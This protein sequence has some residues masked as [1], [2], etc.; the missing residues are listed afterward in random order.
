MTRIKIVY[1]ILII[2]FPTIY[3]QLWGSPFIPQ[4]I[5]TTTFQPNYDSLPTDEKNKNCPI[6]N[7][8]EPLVTLT[9]NEF[10]DSSN[11]VVRIYDDI[12]QPLSIS[13]FFITRNKRLINR[14]RECVNGNYYSDNCEQWNNE[15][16]QK[17]RFNNCI[18]IEDT[19][20]LLYL[21]ISNDLSQNKLTGWD[22]L[23]LENLNLKKLN[24]SYNLIGK[25][26]ENALASIEFVD[27]SHN[28]LLQFNLNYTQNNSIPL[29]FLNIA[30]N[31]LESIYLSNAVNLQTLD[32]S[33][34]KIKSLTN[35]IL[36]SNL[37]FVIYASYNKIND[38]DTSNLI[39][40]KY[41]NLSNNN[42]EF[43]NSTTLTTSLIEL[44]LSNNTIILQSNMNETGYIKN[45][46]KNLEGT[47]SLL[48]H[49]FEEIDE[50]HDIKHDVKADSLIE[51]PT[52]TTEYYDSDFSLIFIGDEN[53]VTL[54]YEKFRDSI[55]K[56]VRISDEV[57]QPISLS[58]VF[59]TRNKQRIY[60][61]DCEYH[62]RRWEDCEQKNTECEL[63]AKSHEECILSDITKAPVLILLDIS[64]GHVQNLHS[65]TFATASECLQCLVLNSNE[66]TKIPKE[67]FSS[68]NNLEYLY[69]S[70][71]KITELNISPLTQLKYLNLSNNNIE[72]INSTTLTTSLIALDLSNNTIILQSNMFEYSSNLVELFLNNN[73]I[74]DVPVNTFYEDY[75]TT[76][77]FIQATTEESVVINT[78][79]NKENYLRDM[80]NLTNQQ[81]H[82]SSVLLNNDSSLNQFQYDYSIKYNN[83]SMPPL[84]SALLQ[85]INKI[86]TNKTDEIKESL[87]KLDN[88]TSLLLNKLEI[89]EKKDVI[90]KHEVDGIYIDAD[91]SPINAW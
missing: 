26:D 44:D 86:I 69:L 18:Q 58:S 3:S 88:T 40:L 63:D 19:P 43:I 57:E 47:T 11:K 8:H 4:V 68:L 39:G 84:F 35:C 87:Q 62:Y 13:S 77:Y 29:N 31:Q 73:A 28:F 17:F 64:N 89:F 20:V 45:S 72:F 78:H 76:N 70:H 2:S 49:K 82:L 22:S 30:N 71:N 21:D 16:E 81:E 23:L 42:I 9:Y 50:L 41:L 83:E 12:E 15:C 91:L 67:I 33:H 74:N 32:I 14:H 7:R 25:L 90:K 51:A 59:I 48:L 85:N 79:V 34:N 54:T 66:I 38:F 6:Y 75:N 24:L 80:I 52:F 10:R 55:D 61:Y 60:Q 46:L 37:L 27:I 1:C 56:V 53:V 65:N 5:E 36:N